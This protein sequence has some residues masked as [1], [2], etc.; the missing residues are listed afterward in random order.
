MRY[1]VRVAGESRS[2]PEAHPFLDGGVDG[3]DVLVLAGSQATLPSDAARYA[4]IV[5]ELG[6]ECLAA[7]P[8]VD[9]QAPN[10]LGFARWR[11]GGSAPSDLVELVKLDGSSDEAIAAA[12]A[13][14][15]QAGLEVSLCA[16]RAGRIID[17]LMRPQFNLALGAVDDGLATAGDMDQCLKLGLGYRKGILEP[18]LASGLEHHYAVTSALFET[19]GLPQ[20]APARAAVVAHQKARRG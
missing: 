17:R 5:V 10:I 12:R 2:F 20:Y 4:A 1:E 13:A 14:F 18:L 9:E 7:H 16:D 11:L 15:E 3:A 19:Y 8:G 6:D